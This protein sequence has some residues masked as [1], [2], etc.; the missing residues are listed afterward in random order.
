MLDGFLTEP[1]L[2][3]L[4]NRVLELEFESSSLSLS[5]KQGD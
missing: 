5:D 2:Q 4:S 3:S 1:K